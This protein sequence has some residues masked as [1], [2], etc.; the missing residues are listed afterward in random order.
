MCLPC[1]LQNGFGHTVNWF[2]ERKY[3][4]GESK[5]VVKC[6]YVY[7]TTNSLWMR[8]IYSIVHEG[9]GEDR[10][11]SVQIF[12]CII[13]NKTS[14]YVQADDGCVDGLW[15]RRSS[16][17]HAMTLFVFALNSIIRIFFWKCDRSNFWWRERKTHA[18]SFE[19]WNYLFQPWRSRA[20]RVENKDFIVYCVSVWQV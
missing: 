6:V 11:I 15:A 10:S 8:N 14:R 18:D 13:C 19:N 16:S 4:Q 3:P 17:S 2:G 20:K 5:L 12:V 9:R 7:I 1:V